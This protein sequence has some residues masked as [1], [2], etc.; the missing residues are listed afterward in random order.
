MVSNL[1][2]VK[3][4]KTLI[5]KLD[6]PL[7]DGSGSGVYVYYVKYGDAEKIAKTLKS[8]IKPNKSSSKKGTKSTPSYLLNLP[9]SVFQ[10][11]EIQITF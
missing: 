6:F 11:K 3:K 9:R 2:G 7:E 4:I 5:K 10:D 1:I 8:V